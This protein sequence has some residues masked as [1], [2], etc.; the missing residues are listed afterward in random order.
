MKNKDVP[1]Y[2]LEKIE[3]VVFNFNTRD[4][5]LF[6]KSDSNIIEVRE[7]DSEFYFRIV[8]YN[9]TGGNHLITV[10]Q[11]PNS[12]VINKEDTYQIDV[13]ILDAKLKG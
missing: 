6:T 4:R 5:F 8:K 9:F 2:Y 10:S 7:R 1:I 3:S 13:G 12:S 11:Y